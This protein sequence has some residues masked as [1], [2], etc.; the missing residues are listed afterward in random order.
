[1][2][3]IIPHVARDLHRQNIEGVVQA[4]LLD[5]GV[6]L[7]VNYIEQNYDSYKRSHYD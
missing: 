3:G 5:A 6:S 4:A 2:G 7:Q 1:M